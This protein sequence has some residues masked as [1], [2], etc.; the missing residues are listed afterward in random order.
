MKYMLIGCLGFACCF[1]SSMSAQADIHN[2]VNGQVSGNE[3]FMEYDFQAMLDSIDALNAML[4]GDAPVGE[5]DRFGGGEVYILGLVLSGADLQ[6]AD[7]TSDNGI[8][9]VDDLLMDNSDL[10]G[11]KWEGTSIRT[12]MLDQG[13]FSNADFSASTVDNFA[14]FGVNLNGAIFSE[15][16]IGSENMH[17]EEVYGSGVLFNVSVVLE[18]IV[19]NFHLPDADFSNS[20]LEGV[21]FNNTNS[22]QA[23]LGMY[24]GLD[25]YG[26]PD[27]DFTNATLKSVAF[28]GVDLSNA[29]F[30]GATFEDCYWENAYVEGC[31]GCD[32]IEINGD[33]ICQ[34]PP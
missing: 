17:M 26:L 28:I 1:A 13:N 21:I 15:T 23:D 33:Y 9:G 25:R 22:D 31:I 27:S 6:N 29:D 30:T 32:C 8:N 34:T 16:V 10:S 19:E 20:Y 24:Q 2:F 11:S 5:G 3:I 12:M 4:D 7:M 14:L 18:G